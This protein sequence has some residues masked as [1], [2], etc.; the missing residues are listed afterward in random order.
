MA[1][2]VGSPPADAAPETDAA[3]RPHPG[4]R[5]AVL[6]DAKI[7]AALRSERH[8]FRSTL[9]A[10]LQVVRLMLVTDAFLGQVAYRLKV[11][12]VQR[13]IPV[14]P[15]IAQRVAIGSAQISI[16]DHVVVDPGVFVPHGQVV[17]EGVSKVGAGAVLNPWVTIG[18]QGPGVEGPTIGALAVI[19]TGAK[20]LGPVTV[21]HR[22]RVGANAV[23]VDDVPD[24]TTVV[25]MPARA[26]KAD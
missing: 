20:V 1:D 8:E 26:V 10:V 6:A 7:A 16:G 18:L 19:G 14:L 25:G 24:G 15:A 4:F 22:S 2:V 9:D 11:A 17:I 13:R 21:G 23:V 5:R 3:Q 12:L